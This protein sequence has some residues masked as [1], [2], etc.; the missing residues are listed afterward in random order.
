MTT[1]SFQQILHTIPTQPGIYKYYDKEHVLLYVGKAKNLKKRISSY[2]NKNLT[3]Y[4][5]H[6]LV[7]RIDTI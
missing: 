2:F 4:K 3:S 1:A 5:T 7:Q 6:E